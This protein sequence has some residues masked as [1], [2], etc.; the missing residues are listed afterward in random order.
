MDI[1]AITSATVNAAAATGSGARTPPFVQTAA[2]ALGM[3]SSDVLAAL[4]SG[5]SLADLAQQQNVPVDTLT[6]ALAAA[7]PQGSSDVDQRVNDL[8]NRHGL[9]GH[10]HAGAARAA[11]G[12]DGS[13]TQTLSALSQLLGTDPSSL[14]QQLQSGTS[15]SD[16]LTA[17]GVNLVTL[18]SQ[19]Q[20]G[21]LVDTQG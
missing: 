11:S 7:A 5:K 6:G 13:A 16:M 2:K 15:L 4:K 12:A 1:S 14:V 21:L 20:K 18:S 8:V 19:L 3:S 17:K 9:G 10:H